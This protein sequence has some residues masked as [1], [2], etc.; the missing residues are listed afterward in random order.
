MGGV[1]DL[2]ALFQSEFRKDYHGFIFEEILEPA[3][4]WRVQAVRHA[5]AWRVFHASARRRRRHLADP[6]LFLALDPA[7]AGPLEPPPAGRGSALRR[8]GGRTGRRPG[9]A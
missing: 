7:A 4:L 8:L 5:G 2:S 9:D 3:R 6:R 1:P